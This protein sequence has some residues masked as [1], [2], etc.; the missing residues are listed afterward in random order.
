MRLFSV[1]R[2]DE[3]FDV[4]AV[5]D[6]WEE[7]A[8]GVGDAVRVLP[9]QAQAPPSREQGVGVAAPPVQQQREHRHRAG[10]SLLVR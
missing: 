1:E 6:R 2:Y 4:E 8:A 9:E 3:V 10:D 5:L 7:E